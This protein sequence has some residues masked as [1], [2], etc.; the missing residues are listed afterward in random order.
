MLAPLPT[1]AKVTPRV[2]GGQ[3]TEVFGPWAAVSRGGGALRAEG[4]APCAGA[5]VR[6]MGEL[7]AGWLRGLGLADGSF[8]AAARSPGPDVGNTG[9]S[10]ARLP[11]T[12][13]CRPARTATSVMLAASTSFCTRLIRATR[14]WIKVLR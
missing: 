12:G 4:L 10:M 8:G 9:R 6:A 14:S 2:G 11:A 7:A 13:R 1:D 5:G 3:V